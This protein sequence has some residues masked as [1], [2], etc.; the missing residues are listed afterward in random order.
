MVIFQRVVV[1]IETMGND[2]LFGG[3]VDRFNLAGEEVNPL[4]HLANRVDDGSKVEVAR[5][6]LVQHGRE[7]EE[8][9]A[10]DQ[11]NLD[12]RVAS[13]RFLELHRRIQ[14]S[15]SAAEDQNSFGLVG[16]HNFSLV[17]SADA[18]AAEP[19]RFFQTARAL[20]ASMPA[21]GETP[22][23]LRDASNIN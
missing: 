11:R 13:E 15:E 10:V 20:L 3:K 18:P 5:R 16:T 12:V 4:E 23:A 19:T 22:R 9:L 17:G 21:E 2:D 7:E 14:A 6:H 1:M 8:V